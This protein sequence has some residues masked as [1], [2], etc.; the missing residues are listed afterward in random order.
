MANPG[1]PYQRAAKSGGK[2]INNGP[3]ERSSSLD[4]LDLV[5]EEVV[6]RIEL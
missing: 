3:N 2:E 1:T 5:L 6:V 4:A